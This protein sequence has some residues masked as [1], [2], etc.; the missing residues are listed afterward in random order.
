VSHRGN[1][2]GKG[3]AR[4]RGPAGVAG[5]LDGGLAKRALSF[6]DGPGAAVDD[7]SR[8]SRGLTQ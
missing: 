6:G 3:A 2:R 1:G 7:Q 5:A 4:D 8:S